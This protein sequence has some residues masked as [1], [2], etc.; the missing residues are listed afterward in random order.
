MAQSNLGRLLTNEGRPEEAVTA[1]Q[2]ILERDADNTDVRSLLAM[3]LAQSG[4][5]AGA[6]SVFDEILASEDG[7]P[8]D[9][10][11]AAV[12]L[13]GAGELE[14]AA[15][16]FEKTI[17]RSPMYKD[18]LQNLVQ[19]YF[20]LE[21]YEALVPHAQTL[22]ELDPFNDYVHRM[23]VRA[24]SQIGEQDPL[25][26]ALDVLQALPFLVDELALV[27]MAA[28]CRISG[29]AV[30]NALDSGTSITLRFTFYDNDGNPVGSEDAQVTVSDPDVAHPFSLSFD[31]E[32]QILGYSYELVG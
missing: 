25:V 4:Q 31:A 12:T 29:V 32:T 17:A 14:K 16:G 18:A 23:Y 7:A 8:L 27:P 5:G 13:Y 20:E 22:L 28:G 10:Y 2:A 26:A 30:N 21:D 3:A 1:F 24:L 9:Y 11:N 6:L 15:L 19:T